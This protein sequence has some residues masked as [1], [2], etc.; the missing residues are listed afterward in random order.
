MGNDSMNKTIAAAIAATLVSSLPAY[1]EP[2]NHWQGGG[3]NPHWDASRSYHEDPGH[4][5]RRLTRSDYVYRGGDGRYYC[6]RDDGTTGLVAGGIGGA[7]L[8]GA[9]GGSALSTLLGAAGGAA[10]GSSIDRG[11]VHCR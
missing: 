5:D 9:I 10:L 4:H 6:R 7:V 1:A 8:G 2:D 3:N 11:E